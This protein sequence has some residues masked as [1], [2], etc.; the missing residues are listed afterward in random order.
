M[1]GRLVPGDRLM[2]VNDVNLESATLDEAVQALKGAE[3]GVVQIGVAKPL[4]LSGGFPEVP[5]EEELEI[6]A[7]TNIATYA[8]QPMHESVSH[9]TSHNYMNLQ[10][11]E[12]SNSLPALAGIVRHQQ[13]SLSS[14]SSESDSEDRVPE[15][16]EQK[17]SPSHARTES[18][19]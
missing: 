14:S 8:T 12:E 5:V 4:P 10:D 11:L 1:D 19:D 18:S 16:I 17:V 13:S 6:S 7:D 9:S 15:M 3:K 2:F